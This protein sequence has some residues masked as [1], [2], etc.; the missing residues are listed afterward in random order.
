M[1]KI[2]IRTTDALAAIACA[3]VLAIGL[4]TFIHGRSLIQSN[5][6]IAT[7][8]A[9]AQLSLSDVQSRLTRMEQ[10]RSKSAK[11]RL[12]FPELTDTD[13]ASLDEAETSLVPFVASPKAANFE[14]A[15]SPGMA[16]PNVAAGQGPF[17]RYFSAVDTE[18]K[19]DF[20]LPTP[21]L[22]IAG[23]DSL[24]PTVQMT[25]ALPSS[26]ANF[27]FEFDTS[28]SFDSPNFWR[29][30]ALIPIAFPPDVT[31]RAGLGYNLFLSH[32]RSLENS[33][34]LHF[35]FRVTAMALPMKWNSIGFETLAKFSQLLAYGLED[36]SAKNEIY[37]LNRQR[38]VYSDE[39]IKRNPLDTFKAGLGECIHANELMGAMLEINGYRYR[40]AGGFNPTFRNAYPGGGHAAIEVF[41]GKKWE[42]M[43]P[44][45]DNHVPGVGI[46]D[47]SHHPAGNTLIAR[48]NRTKF[49]SAQFE[50]LTLANLFRYRMYSDAAGR[51]PPATMLQLAGAEDHYGL[52]WELRKITPD[53]RLDIDRDLPK[54]LQIHVRARYIVTACA[55]SHAVSCADRAAR[56]SPWA[57]ASFTIDPVKLLRQQQDVVELPKR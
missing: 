21:G 52:D 6:A 43:D 54:H 37:V 30:P 44:Y 55:V 40:T 24:Y 19:I 1:P 13:I 50:D 5:A 16:T 17:S 29:S 2:Q 42:Y 20:T 10:W 38:V 7:G 12:L 31:S 8:L 23:A 48:V 32:M 53:E 56:A 36:K 39:T 18:V 35:P 22:E 27:Y 26:Q 41:N 28:S 47:L 34:V 15:L 11:I 14:R 33:P 3:G 49:P 4:V 46:T 9:Q 57:Q 25:G 45:L 51:L